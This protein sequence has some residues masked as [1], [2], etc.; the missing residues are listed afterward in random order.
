MLRS[1]LTFLPVVSRHLLR[2]FAGLFV[3]IVLAFVTLYLVVDFFD[4]LDILLKNQATPLSAMRYFAFKIPLIVTQTLPAAAM[5]A[6][7][8]SLG[9]LSRH[10][11]ITVLRAS[12]ISLFQTALPLLA[13]AIVISIGTLLWN[14]TVV[15]YCAR[16]YQYVNVVEI[17]KRPQRGIL[18]EREVWYHG[19]AGFYNIAHIDPRRDTLFGLTIYRTDTSFSLRSIVE[20]A[21][22][23]WTG[24]AW[25]LS[26]AMERT[27]DRDGEVV[28]RP[29]DPADLPIQETLNDFLEVRREP[30]EL[31]YLALREHVHELTR[32]GIDSSSYLVDL[33]L[34]LAVPFATLVLA[35]IAIP[36]A[37]RVQRHPSLPVIVLAGF[38]I[39][40]A[41]WVVLALANSLGQSGVLP[42]LAA[43]WAANT[44][45]A[46][47]GGALFLTS[48]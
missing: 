44:I 28:T 4:R 25:L 2:E 47:V 13:L 3:P 40:F 19:A 35:G 15:P 9:I 23:R 31:S 8:L 39:G 45:C 48:E 20:V 6:M 41:Y 16:Q 46:L 11:E 1:H 37:G 14:E 27:T 36:L 26:G 29:V 18:N 30:E 21:T 32:K 22:A 10:N 43:A 7:L 34:K 38:G 17:R 33:N 42:P 5:A 24:S 12:G